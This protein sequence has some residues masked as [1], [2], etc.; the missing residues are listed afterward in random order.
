MLMAVL[1][2]STSTANSA[3]EGDKYKEAKTTASTPYLIHF[4][5]ASNAALSR[6]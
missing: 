6:R 1:K 4:S 2:G 3:K 5:L